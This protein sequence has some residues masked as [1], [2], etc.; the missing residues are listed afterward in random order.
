MKPY[1]HPKIFERVHYALLDMFNSIELNR[2]DAN[3][4]IVKILRVP[5]V[6][7]YDKNIA[8]FVMNT[9]SKNKESK[10]SAPI[11]GLRFTGLSPNNEGK[12]TSNHIR[13]IFNSD[14][15]TYSRDANPM[16]Y[17]LNYTLSLYTETAADY[18]QLVEQIVPYFDNW[19]ALRIKEFEFNNL[20]RD[21]PIGLTGMTPSFQDEERDKHRSLSMDFNLQLKVDFYKPLMVSNIIKF[22]ESNITLDK[23]NVGVI[24]NTGIENMDIED[25]SKALNEIVEI[26]G[27]AKSLVVSTIESK[28]DNSFTITL[29]SVLN[30]ET[31]TLMLELPLGAKITYAEVFVTERFND[32]DTT[33]SI[34]SEASPQLVMATSDSNPFVQTRYS[35]FTNVKLNT[36]TQIFVYFNQADAT[37]GSAEIKIKYELT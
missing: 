31:K 20:E 29:A 8:E 13:K 25:Y 14:S 26:G 2:Y 18:F 15:N 11:L 28:S 3:S 27:I 34:G 1:Y 17:I 4:N 6:F 7:I 23:Q 9:T 21:I 37:T 33:I 36:N 24:K 30:P 10:H 32:L 19:R 22:I 5:I 12:T 35:I 16:P